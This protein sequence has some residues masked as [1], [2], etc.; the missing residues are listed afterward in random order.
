MTTLAKNLEWRSVVDDDGCYRRWRGWKLGCLRRV[1]DA[2][3]VEIDDALRGDLGALRARIS[4]MNFAFYRLRDDDAN[5]APAVRNMAFLALCRRL[6]LRRV[7]GNRFADAAGV[8]AICVGGDEARRGF[9]PYS[10]RAL[11][12]H[13]DGYYDARRVGGFAMHTVRAAACGGAN[14]FLDHEVLYMLLRDRDPALA[15]CLFAPDVLTIPAG[16]GADDAHRP[17]FTG[18]VFALADGRLHMAFTMRQRNIAWKNS[19]VV[20]AAVAAI[21]EILNDENNPYV[22][23]HRFAAGE[24]VICNNVLHDRAAFVD[25]D[26]AGR[27]VLRAR[28]YDSVAVNNDDSLS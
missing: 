25:D 6:G 3:V 1:L 9:V 17:A 24:G 12:W 11:N 5:D 18:P 7:A 23:R 20:R 28:F 14:R 27:L 13:T 2:G 4:A 26:A 19:R 22:V 10:N 8:S 15:A 21:G 16:V